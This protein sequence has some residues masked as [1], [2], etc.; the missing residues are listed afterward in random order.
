M[1]RAA[2]VSAPDATG[3]LPMRVVIPLLL[4]TLIW[5]STWTAIRHQ[6]GMVDPSWSIAYRFAIAAVTMYVL[7]RRE[8]APTG[9]SRDQVPLVATIALA[10]FLLNF[11]C[12]YHAEAY[13]TSG[14]VA[15]I[16]SLLIV[17]NAIFGRL[18]MGHRVGLS[19]IVGT[20]MAVAGLALLFEPQIG[21]MQGGGGHVALGVALSFGAVLSASVGN[22]L[23]ASNRA[24]RMHWAT[25]LLWAMGLASLFNA[26]LALATAGPPTFDPRPAYWIA[27]LYLGLLGTALS[28]PVYLSVI[29]L[30]GPARAAYSGIFVPIVAMGFSTIL[31]GYRWTPE[32]IAGSVLAVA[33]LFFAMRGR[34]VTPE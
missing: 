1:S 32:A 33:G 34:A 3:A 28:F 30:I 11:V 14:L 17:P 4:C 6:L 16:F 5:G 27:T 31:E 19:F 18:F 20:A 8:G 7:A 15:M 25:L 29:R 12:I 24:N 26:L 22:L 2:P 10:Q 13:I 23:Q 21:A 9:I